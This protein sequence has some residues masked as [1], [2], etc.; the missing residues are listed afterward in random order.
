MR[1]AASPTDLGS[2]RSLAENPPFF[3]GVQCA[4]VRVRV[5][6]CGSTAHVAIKKRPPPPPMLFQAARRTGPL[7]ELGRSDGATEARRPR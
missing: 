2:H 7:L 5:C 3:A 1:H 4:G 6:R